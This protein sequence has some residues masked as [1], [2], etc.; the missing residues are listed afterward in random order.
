MRACTHLTLRLLSLLS[1][2][3]ASISSAA[4]NYETDLL[5]ILKESCLG[6]HNP[7][8]MKAD[9]DL[10]THAGVMKGGSSGVCVKPGSA[11]TSLLYRVVAHMEEPEMPP[12][13]PQLAAAQLEIFKSW[14]AGGCLETAGG[15]AA[16]PRGAALETILPTK[17]ASNEPGPMP[18]NLPASKLPPVTASGPAIAMAASPNAPLLAVGGHERILLFNTTTNAPLGSIPFPER[19][20]H[21]L[22]FSPNGQI[23]LAAGGHGSHSGKVVI[24]DVKSG[25]RISEVAT[26]ATD[27]ILAA[28]ISPDLSQ[29]ACGGPDKLVKIYATKDSK[30]IRK[31]KKH[32]DWVTSVAYAPDGDKLATGDRSGGLHLWAT[33]TGTILYT[34]AEH[35]ARIASLSW[36][37]DAAILASA[38]ED[39]KMILWDTTEGWA[40]KSTTPH[41]TL[42]EKPKGTAFKVPGVT[43]VHFAPDGRLLTAGRDNAVRLFLTNGNQQLALA[44][45]ADLPTKAVVGQNGQWFATGDIA[46]NIRLYSLPPAPEKAPK[47][48]G[49]FTT[50]G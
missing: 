49:K 5:P 20:L 22:T 48:I 45:L 12:K 25:K 17:L 39:G 29:I 35:Q 34:L 31:I 47:E 3:L 11:D 46:G 18:E 8:K 7:D 42:K 41:N 9:L 28:D 36:R 43:S 33:D 6:C 15:T 19:T 38:G 24:I 44:D 27:S 23:L 37:A 13:K 21:F 26:E 4:P 1:P 16:K 14:I 50:Q 10:S 40:A 2:L 30:L 32:T